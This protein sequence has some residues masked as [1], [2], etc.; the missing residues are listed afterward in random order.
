MHIGVNLYALTLRGGG[1]RQYVLQLL[2]W[3]VRRSDHRLVLFHAAQGQPSVAL[4][5]RQLTANERR[6][7][8]VVEIEHQDEIYRHARRFDLYFCPLN[9]LA[10]SLLDRPTVATLADVQEQFF[11]QYFTA[12][13]LALRA[14]VYPRMAH[15]ATLLI[16]LSE[17]S[18]QSIGEAFGVA[19]DK[20]RVTHLA[21]NE[22]ALSAAAEWPASLPRL[23]ERF[24]FYP[25]N[26]YPHKNHDMLLRA[27]RVLNDRLGV[28]CGCV[29]TGHEA[30]P[31]IDIRERIAAQGLTGKALWLEYVAGGAL[32]YL[33]EHA[34]A[35]CFPSRFE[36]FGMPLAEAMWHG[37]P[38]IATPLASIPEV[39]GDA[40][41]LVEPDERALADA[42]ARLTRDGS[43]RQ[44]LIRRGLERVR[45]FSA[46]SLADATLAIFDEAVDRFHVPRQTSCEPVTYVVRG[47]EAGAA[48]AATLASLAAEVGEHDEVL[49]LANAGSMAAKT[50]SLCDNLPG[51][52]LLDG[53][54][55]DTGWL[56]QVRH[57]LVCVVREG[58]RVCEGA[59]ATAA[60]ALCE[61]D[62]CQATV[63][64]A[65][66][67]DAAGSLLSSR[68][69]TPRAGI[70]PCGEPVPPCVV[71][72][73]RAFLNEHKQL[74][75]A[76]LW[77]NRLLHAA[78][79]RVHIACRTLAHIDVEIERRLWP[80]PGLM[81]QLVE[82]CRR[83]GA[84]QAVGPVRVLTSHLLHGLY[85]LRRPAKA[86]LAVMPRWLRAW[87]R[88]LYAR[89]IRFYAIE[90]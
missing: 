66:G 6:R 72:W 78:G 20:V 14:D 56:N 58:D 61:S 2:P 29:M 39:V 64:E 26:L 22:E 79:D 32:R 80:A 81:G 1:M 30:S 54:G 50:R 3:L 35:L 85:R 47:S 53:G 8:E 71:Y 57:D 38:V 62:D 48:L 24:V 17:F 42:I 84:V 13:Q 76:P 31:G 73:K 4:I 88:S 28:D 82:S 65:L 37:C 70:Q 18:K 89:T 44:D 12:E 90:R 23:P 77:T 36:G 27:V 11:P 10:P 74:L 21:P 60:A 41:L 75:T 69:V 43:L 5:L 15:A 52:R 40:G 68:Y 49:V 34:V 16:T 63:G 83:R 45:Q 7:V 33:Y 9:G 19:A 86:V 55:G 59:R 67:C 46:A 25:A 87:S 51:A